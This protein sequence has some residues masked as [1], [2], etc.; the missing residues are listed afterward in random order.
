MTIRVSAKANSS[1]GLSPVIP[2]ALL[3]SNS[4]QAMYNPFSWLTLS[5]RVLKAGRRGRLRPQGAIGADRRSV[6]IGR[7]PAGFLEGQTRLLRAES[8]AGEQLLRLCL[9]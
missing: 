5:L 8:V 4:Y 1:I 2:L 9:G 3:R 7:A 6:Q